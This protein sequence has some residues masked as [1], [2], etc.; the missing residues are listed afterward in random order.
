MQISSLLEKQKK[1]LNKI[2]HL[3][4]IDGWLLD[5]EAAELF[6]CS[7]YIK[8][9]KPIICEIGTW[10]GKSSYVFASAMRE[11]NGILYSIDPFNGE[12]D[13]ASVDD[14]QKEI[15]RLGVSLLNNFE[16][17]MLKYGLQQY[18]KI[19]PMLSREA[20]KKFPESKIDLLFIDGNHDQVSVYEDFKLWAPLIRSGGVIAFHDVEASHVDGPRRIF[21][22]YIVGNTKWRDAHIVGEMGI[23]KKV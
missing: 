5:V 18:V 15:K 21:Q 17:T 14:Y 4:S 10:K 6:K 3:D 19:F 12:G 7:M 23:A 20:R 8:S 9:L 1:I 13:G 22:K 16:N 2:P 11:K